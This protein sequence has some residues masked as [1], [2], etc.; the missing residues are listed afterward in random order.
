MC[1]K[2]NSHYFPILHG[3]INTRSG[4]SE[5]YDFQILLDSRCSSNILM[6]RITLKLKIT[7]DYLMQCQIQA[8][9]IKTG[10]QGT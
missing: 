2:L 10:N 6:R 1:K 9:N 3:C 7:K 4:K 5:V 8:G